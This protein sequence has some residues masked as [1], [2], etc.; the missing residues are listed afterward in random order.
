MTTHQINAIVSLQRSERMLMKAIERS[1]AIGH[2]KQVQYLN[3]Q[4]S[5]T[6]SMISQLQAQ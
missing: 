1:N 2:K 5:N 3:V 4:L 6:K